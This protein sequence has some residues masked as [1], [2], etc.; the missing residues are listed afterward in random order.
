MGYSC[1]HD[2]LL[3]GAEG[4]VVTPVV[5]VGTAVTFSVDPGHT[6]YR[7]HPPR[8]EN[9]FYHILVTTTPPSSQEV[10]WLGNPNPN[11]NPKPK[12]GTRTLTIGGEQTRTLTT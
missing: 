8:H 6:L 10:C 1:G 3:A 2:N 11:P 9:S 7:G 4:K 12:Q 5:K